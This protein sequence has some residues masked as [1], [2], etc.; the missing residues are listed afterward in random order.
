MKNP[1]V[2]A[3]LC[4]FL[5][6]CGGGN[7]P[8]G[9][10]TVK[11]IP[12]ISG[13]TNNMPAGFQVIGDGGV[14]QIDENYI[15][16]GFIQKGTVDT[17]Y[18]YNSSVEITGDAPIICLRALNTF[19][20]IQ[21]VG[22]LGNTYTYTF[23]GTADETIE[24]FLFDKV[25]PGSAAPFGLNVYKADGTLAYSSTSKPMIMTAVGASDTT[26]SG[27]TGKYAAC[28]SS[29]RI[30]AVPASPNYDILIEG[31]KVSATSATTQG[32]MWAQSFTPD[33]NNSPG[34]LFLVNVDNL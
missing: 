21:A 33:A 31:V 1:I 20:S 10:I 14:V 30:T 16:Y 9:D 28:L 25:P 5:V 4:L 27:P 12:A 29:P 19:V 22:K 8:S 6:A 32:I 2:L 3:A 23:R 18:A 34:L 11:K 15:N 26:V 17:S 24:W 13:A 7:D